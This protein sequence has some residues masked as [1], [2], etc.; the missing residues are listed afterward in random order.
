[1]IIAIDGPA[2]AGK[3]T[4]ARA[5]AE[6]FGLAYIDTGAMYRAVALAATEEHLRLPRDAAAIV[7]LAHTLPIELRDRGRRIFIGAREVSDAIRTAE[8]S[9]FTS[10]I[11]ALAGVRE[12]MVQQQRRLAEHSQEECGGAVLEGRDIQTV[13]CPH[14]EVKIFL[15]A[16]PQTRAE[17]RLSQ[18]QEK[19]DAV[20]LALAQH[21]IGA[22]DERDSKRE[23][24]PLRAAPDA[25]LLSTDHLSPNE[26]M[27]RIAEIIQSK[28]GGYESAN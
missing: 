19:G 26:V 18:W 23:V 7:A 4:T 3:S 24:A 9:Q 1:M 10:E 27:E 20:N 11:S 16:D 25:V 6:R 17:R 2:G 21:D 13:V 14:A 22:R 5:V 28:R 15:T 8:I 12:A